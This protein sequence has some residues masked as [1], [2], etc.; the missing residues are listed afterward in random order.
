[1]LHSMV[2]CD[3]V[4]CLSMVTEMLTKNDY[5]GTPTKGSDRI[6]SDA[7]YIVAL[8]TPVAVLLAMYARITIEDHECASLYC[9]SP[10]HTTTYGIHGS[11]TYAMLAVDVPTSDEPRVLSSIYVC[12]Q[13]TQDPTRAQHQHTHFTKIAAAY[14]MSTPLSRS[15]VAGVPAHADTASA[16]HQSAN[17][18]DEGEH[19]CI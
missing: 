11:L 2:F 19:Y 5:V 1:M 10:V 13:P 6:T 15:V 16:K 8:H 14:C 4:C 18:S 7:L 12:I 17:N 9:R 3:I